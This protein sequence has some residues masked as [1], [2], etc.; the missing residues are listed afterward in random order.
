MILKK[1]VIKNFRS[2]K[3]QVI[4]M[5]ESCLILLGK[6]EAGK[7]NF[8]KAIA[9]VFGQYQ[10]T[11]KDKR[12]KI[13]EEV[14]ENYFIR[15]IISLTE[16]DF[17]DIHNRF[18][19]KYSNTEK[20]ILKN[21]K[22]LLE[23]IKVFFYEF[24]I[25]INIGEGE[26][27]YCTYWTYSGKD[28]ELENEVYLDGTAFNIEKKGKNQ[29]FDNIISLVHNIIIEK[30]N[31]SSYRCH[32]WQSGNSLMIPD[33]INLNDFISNPDK[34][35]SLNNIFVSCGYRNIKN[36]FSDFHAQDGDHSNLLQKV[37]EQTSELFQSIWEDFKGTKIEL[38]NIGSDLKIKIVNKTKFSFEDRS[39]GFKKLISILIALSTKV[40]SDQIGERDII[41]IDEPDQS[42]YPTSAEYLR[43]ELI[44]IGKTAKVIYATHSSYMIDSNCIERHMIVEKKDDIS[45]INKQSENAPFSEDELLRRA[46][47][48]SIFEVIKAKNI[49]FEGW[50]D[51]EL[52]RKYCAFFEKN[53]EF[54]QIG[55][56]YLGGISGVETLVQL[57]ILANKKFVIVAD[58]DEMSKSKRKE[59]EEKYEEYSKSWLSY[60]DVIQD[61]I[62]MEDFISTKKIEK[63]IKIEFPGFIYN[64]LKKALDNIDDVV[65][66]DKEKKQ[67]IKKELIKELSKK[68]I[69][70]TYSNFI[71][72]L[73]KKIEEM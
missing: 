9:S 51:K 34:Y 50:L 18:T 30:Y 56:V 45:T 58:S 14:I 39:D 29:L 28:Y 38:L 68:D 27:P 46:I 25:Q 21:N 69:N 20:I 10:V 72:H 55:V 47:G 5:N 70:E 7:S 53:K 73:M 35:E 49:I 42:L 52:F 62:T 3:D 4:N 61:V 12:K 65:K 26:K 6:N 37:S 64:N 66:K 19:A 67:K 2:I 15:A 63:H 32:Y 11:E 40:R 36:A 33:G 44:K 24:L 54:N 16:D 60:G 48:S 43:D 59:F 17:I 23:M 31:E 8:L 13:G 71:E 57:L 22:T 1:I 41:L